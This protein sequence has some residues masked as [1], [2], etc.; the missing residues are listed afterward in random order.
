MHKQ[1]ALTLFSQL[2]SLV[3]LQSLH[4]GDSDEGSCCAISPSCT[5]I[6]ASHLGLTHCLHACSSH[7]AQYAR[8]V[9]HL[10]CV[11][12]IRCCRGCNIM[13]IRLSH[14]AVNRYVTGEKGS[15]A[16]L[17]RVLRPIMWRN[18]K[19]STAGLG[20]DLPP[21]TLTLTRLHFI[22][23]EHTFYSHILEKTREAR[24]ALHQHNH[25]NTAAGPSMESPS[26]SGWCQLC[27]ASLMLSPACLCPCSA[28][29]L[30]LVLMYPTNV[31]L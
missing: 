29:V 6:E 3:L 24:D 25:F 27:C 4:H 15:A 18:S 12:S 26:Q 17:A 16:Q 31:G 28:L 1:R 14:V 5:A 22:P 8:R 19:R 20:L 2:V 10:L 23:A 21:R 9:A 30:A 13:L 11:P 7:L